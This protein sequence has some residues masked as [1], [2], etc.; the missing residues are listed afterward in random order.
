[1]KDYNLIE[2]GPSK[3]KMTSWN[4]DNT[5]TAGGTKKHQKKMLI[6]NTQIKYA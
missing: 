3:I 4:D 2:N 5:S 1:M 6:T